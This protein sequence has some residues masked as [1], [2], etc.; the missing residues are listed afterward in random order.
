MAQW[1]AL[2][3][4][5]TALY[6]TLSEERKLPFYEM[7]LVSTRLQANLNRLYASGES[8][9]GLKLTIVAKS[10]LYATQARS[11]ANLHADRALE[12]FDRDADL[13]DEFHHIQNGKWN[14]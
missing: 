1:D 8:H 14:Q 2:E 7:V 6:E 11:A 12:L 5:A 9:V 10:N 3:Q 4:R 13:T